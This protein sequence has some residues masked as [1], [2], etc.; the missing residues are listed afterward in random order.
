MGG[1]PVFVNT[2]FRCLATVSDRYSF[3][4]LWRP[5]FTSRLAAEDRWHLNGLATE[6]GAP[7]FVT[8]CS[9]SDEAKS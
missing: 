6:G 3:E 9:R 1:R 5:T 8:A 7:R 2:L 4:P